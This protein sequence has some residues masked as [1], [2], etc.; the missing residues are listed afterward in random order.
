MSLPPTTG[1]HLHTMFP[2]CTDL[3]PR[4]DSQYFGER[5][6]ATI[7]ALGHTDTLINEYLAF[8]D[9]VFYATAESPRTPPQYNGVYGAG[10]D[11]T[12][13][14]YGFAFSNYY[15]SLAQYQF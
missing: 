7:A 13:Y 9:T 3:A 14:T 6:N 15:P 4:I 10:M 1:D 5:V 11:S 8:A 12:E 2:T